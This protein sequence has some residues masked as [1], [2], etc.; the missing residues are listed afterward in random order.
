VEGKVLIMRKLP[1][2]AAPVLIAP[3]LAGC[4]SGISNIC[5][6]TECLWTERSAPSSNGC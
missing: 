5:I 2:A 3:G 1:L 6:D 4:R